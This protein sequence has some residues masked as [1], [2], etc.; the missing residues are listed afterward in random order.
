MY[1]VTE[2]LTK[3]LAKRAIYFFDITLR[4][5]KI[6]RFNFFPHCFQIF[7]SCEIIIFVNPLSVWQ[8]SSIVLS[9]LVLFLDHFGTSLVL[10]KLYN[11]RCAT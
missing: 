6:L 2:C 5:D 9:K 11:S 1:D 8:D 7:M 10:S 3:I 4:E